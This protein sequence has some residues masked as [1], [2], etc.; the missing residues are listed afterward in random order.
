MPMT[1]TENHA[2][3]LFEAYLRS[4]Q[5]DFAY[6]PNVPGRTKHPDYK[7]ELDGKPYWFEVK[8]FVDP[9]SPPMG[10]YDPTPPFEE[11]IDQARKK[12][13]E[14]KDACCVLV[15]HS[16][17]SIHRLPMI[18]T[19]VSAA[20]GERVVLEPR[21]G[22]TLADEPLRF[23]FY[24]NAK[25]RPDANTTI[26]AIM[27]LQHFQLE[28]RWVEAFYRIR[29][30]LEVREEV[31]PFAYAEEFELMKNVE[32]KVE[33]ENSVRVVI[34]EN[35]YARIPIPQGRF[36]GRLDQRWGVKD[37]SGWYT[38]ISMGSELERLRARER[39]VPY[40]VL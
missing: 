17:K 23:K 1:P 33:F 34:L 21:C 39:P 13:A 28:S 19:V 38:L 16:C 24:G 14:F 4:L 29:R 12:F 32:N 8:E 22:Q 2:E 9:E 30:K 15:L 26:S 5:I 6:E 3:M 7:V 20:F 10:G 37:L 31:G 27:I 40:L 11:K 36:L 25:L 18:S 35:P